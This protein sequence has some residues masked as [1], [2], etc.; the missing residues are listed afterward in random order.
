MVAILVVGIDVCVFG[1]DH[2]IFL[3][4]VHSMNMR[5]RPVRATPPKTPPTMA[6]TGVDLE[7]EFVAGRDRE[8][9][10]LTLDVVVV[11]AVLVMLGVLLVIWMLV[12]VLLG[13]S[14]ADNKMV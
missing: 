6:P 10:E 5:N 13:A 2:R 7:T 4:T 12:M 1:R 8:L 3:V 11:L 9:E 14:V